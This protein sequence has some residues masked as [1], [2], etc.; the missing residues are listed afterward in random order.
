MKE[1]GENIINI[2]KE[3]TIQEAGPLACILHGDYWINNMLF[4][5]KDGDFSK[6]LQNR[7]VDFQVSRIGHAVS[8]ILYFLYSSTTPELRAENLD[9]LLSYYF[10]TLTKDLNRLGINISEENYTMKHF[11]QDYRKRST[12]FMV[13][14]LSIIPAIID[15]STVD[16]LQEEDPNATEDKFKLGEK[17]D[18]NPLGISKEIED[19]FKSMSNVSIMVNN[20]MVRDRA[21]GLIGEVKKLQDN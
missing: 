20:K 2:I 17:T 15:K 14:A 4:Q 1:L 6:P 5:Y 13:V 19:K 18:A 10:E 16:L 9:N 12:R 11:L 7:M 3:D 21:V 8:D